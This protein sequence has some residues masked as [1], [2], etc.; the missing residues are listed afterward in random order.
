MR[1]QLIASLHRALDATHPTRLTARHL[2]EQPPSFIVSVGKA[3]L[4]MLEAALERF[5]HTP[6]I[7]V[8][9]AE[10]RPKGAHPGGVVLP[11]GHP[12]PDGRSLEA[13]QRVLEAVGRLGPEELLLVL[14]SG[15]GSALLCA[16]W[17][18]DLATKQALT[19]ALLRCGADIQEINA[20][21]KHLSRIK[22]GRLA[23]ATQARVLALYLSDVPGDD[24]STI[25]SGPTVPDR[26]TFAE[27]LAVLD[28]YG[29]EFPQVRAHL[30]RG[31]AGEIPESPKPGDPLFQRVENRLVG[32]N[33]ALLEAARTYWQGLGLPAV[34]LSDRFQGEAQALARF[35]AALVES[36]RAHHQPFAPP[37]V[38]LSG[39]E[40][41]VRVRGAGRGG[42][43]QE[44]LGW[45]GYYLGERG[46]WAL[47]ADSDGIDGNTEVAGALLAPDTWA[48][49]QRLGLDLKAHLEQN[50][51][52]AFFRALG[53]LLITGETQSNLND[54]R[55]LVVGQGLDIF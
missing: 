14:V 42:R 23:A 36:I 34:I 40:A 26:S 8:P 9:K 11:A 53:D 49:S 22:G 29:L 24:L 16:P 33:M 43:N 39:G 52:H 7:A 54:F 31:L 30:R 10:G 46:V 41:S 48:R 37:V 3:A 18:V 13:A 5:P 1:E 44:F 27:A 2:P 20:V 55:A 51:T 50:D 35:H 15:G 6:Y 25:A 17:G 12:V 38:L 19:Q 4:T 21:R 28:R 45:L 32:G 47:A